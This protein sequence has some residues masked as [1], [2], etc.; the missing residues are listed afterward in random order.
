[1]LSSNY[2]SRDGAPCNVLVVDRALFFASAAPKEIPFKEH[3]IVCYPP[4]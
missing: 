4:T 1:M 2:R 3:C